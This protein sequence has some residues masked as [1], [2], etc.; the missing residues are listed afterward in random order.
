MSATKKK[1]GR[2]KEKEKGWRVLSRRIWAHWRNQKRLLW[3]C[4]HIWRMKR[5]GKN[6]SQ[7]EQGCVENW[8]NSL[9]VS[10]KNAVCYEQGEVGPRMALKPYGKGCRP[11]YGTEKPLECVALGVGWHCL[12]QLWLCCREWVIMGPKVKAE[13]LDLWERDT[14]VVAAE[15]ERDTK[16]WETLWELNL[17]GCMW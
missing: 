1:K 10:Q 9:K 7:R 15:M 6:F 4:N 3:G 5:W 14:K 11:H 16:I 13:R 2:K 12:R 8:L 17:Q